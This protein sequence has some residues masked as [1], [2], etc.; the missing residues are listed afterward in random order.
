MILGAVQNYGWFR[1]QKLIH[2]LL[3]FLPGKHSVHIDPDLPFLKGNLRKSRGFQQRIGFTFDQVLYRV[4]MGIDMSFPV[5]DVKPRDAQENERLVVTWFQSM[6][7]RVE[8]TLAR[9]LRDLSAVPPTYAPT[10]GGAVVGNSSLMANV[11]SEL[12]VAMSSPAAGPAYAATLVRGTSGSDLLA[13]CTGIREEARSRRDHAQ[14]QLDDHLY[15]QQ[16]QAQ[17]AF[18]HANVLNIGRHFRDFV[19]QTRNLYLT[20]AEVLTYQTVMNLMDAVAEQVRRLANEFTDPFRKTMAN[21]FTVFAANRAELEAFADKKNPYE[22]PLVSMN[23][24]LPTLN[25][26]AFVVSTQDGK[27][28]RGFEA[29]YTEM[30]RLRRHGFTQSEFERTQ[31]NL[32]RSVERSYTNRNDRYNGSFVQTYLSNFQKNTPMPDALTEW[33]LDS[34]LICSINVDMVNDFANKT[35]TENNQVTS[36]TQVMVVDIVATIKVLMPV[37]GSGVLTNTIEFSNFTY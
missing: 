12:R 14:F 33:Q 20:Q 7:A 10:I 1:L 28:N 27:I 11:L 22:M 16:Q 34:M 29:I 35:L 32:L 4:R 36:Y 15:F 24:L 5:P 23:D 2:N 30:E 6:F 31:K 19:N 8:G 37:S 25:A 17:N 21:L 26:T 9:N 3:F 18:R 13:A